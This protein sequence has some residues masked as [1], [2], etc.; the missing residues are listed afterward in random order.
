MT[1]VETQRS[2]VRQNSLFLGPRYTWFLLL[3][4]FVALWVAGAWAR[5][6]LSETQM[7]TSERQF[8]PNCGVLQTVSKTNPQL[9]NQPPQKLR[10]KLQDV[11]SQ[12]RTQMESNYLLASH[13]Y[14]RM[15]VKSSQT[16]KSNNTNAPH[17]LNGNR[18]TTNPV[19]KQPVCSL[20]PAA[21]NKRARNF[22]S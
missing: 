5:R 3:L 20:V 9:R 19:R 1:Q 15:W 4:F 21:Q 22:D 13:V 6:L 18:P 8:V 11:L 12:T 7:N 17:I 10:R 2:R 16:S 14:V